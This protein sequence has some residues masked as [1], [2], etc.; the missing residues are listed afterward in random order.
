VR[1]GILPAGDPVLTAL[2]LIALGA[3]CA[4]WYQ[5]DYDV[6]PAAI[7]RS[8]LGLLIRPSDAEPPPRGKSRADRR[9]S[10]ISGGK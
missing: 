9:G 10:P 8:I 5:R 2:N 1:A 4:Q 3:W 7:E 6:P